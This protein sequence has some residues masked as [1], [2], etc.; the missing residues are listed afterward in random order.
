MLLQRCDPEFANS[1]IRH[2]P[3]PVK[4]AQLRLCTPGSAGD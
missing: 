2:S 4:H 3:L 1:I